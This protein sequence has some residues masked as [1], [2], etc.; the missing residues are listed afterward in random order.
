MS[1]NDTHVG[2]RTAV[3]ASHEINCQA[4]RIDPSMQLADREPYSQL[5]ES[6]LSKFKDN[7]KNLNDN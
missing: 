6:L 3:D 5:P 7:L 1:A 4:L 2:A